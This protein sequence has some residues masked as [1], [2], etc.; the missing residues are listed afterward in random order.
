M[1]SQ[2]T[3]E[4]TPEE[5]E[6]LRNAMKQLRDRLVDLSGALEQSA[7]AIEDLGAEQFKEVAADTIAR[8]KG[9]LPQR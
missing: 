6:S 7:T 4:L 3:K 9:K 8:V 2:S 1:N 5:M